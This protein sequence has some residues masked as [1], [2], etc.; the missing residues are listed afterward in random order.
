MSDN[1]NK[2]TQF[3]QELKRRRVIHAIIVYATA[4]FVIKIKPGEEHTG[5]N[6]WKIAIT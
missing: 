3:W 2:L 4:A 5:L 1:P 6:S